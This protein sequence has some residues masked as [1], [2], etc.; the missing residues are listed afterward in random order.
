[1]DR[2]RDSILSI[3]EK[4]QST[5]VRASVVT[6]WMPDE[7]LSVPQANGGVRLSVLYISRI[8]LLSFDDSSLNQYLTIFI[9]CIS[10]KGIRPNSPYRALRLVD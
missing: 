4:K 3:H 10:L 8:T 1:M 9:F 6:S 2:A 5:V 7:F